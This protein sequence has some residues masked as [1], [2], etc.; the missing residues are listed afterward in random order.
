MNYLRVCELL[1]DLKVQSRG[2]KRLFSILINLK[3]SNN[4]F[5]SS[6]FIGYLNQVTPQYVKVHF[7]RSDIVKS[8]AVKN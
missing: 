8:F 1:S 7:P 6:H 3:M 4:P 5:Q 2:S